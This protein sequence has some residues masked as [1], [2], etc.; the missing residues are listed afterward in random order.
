MYVRNAVLVMSLVILCTA[1]SGA[2]CLA[3][4]HAASAV[5]PALA[6]AA[7]S[8]PLQVADLPPVTVIST[9]QHDPVE[10]VKEGRARARVFLAVAEPS[11]A[12]KHMV[13]ELVEVVRLSTEAD[14][15]VV[16]RMPPKTAPALVIGDC[17]ESREA[18]IEADKIPVEGFVVKTA[19]N[20]V[21]LVGSTKTLPPNE[22]RNP[23]DPYGNE[24]TAWAVADFLERFVGVRWYWP[25]EVG[26]RCI[27][28]ATDLV[29][30]PVHYSDQPVFPMRTFYPPRYTLPLKSRWFDKDGITMG[31]PAIP[32]DLKT[33]EMT[34][35]LTCLRG[36]NSWPY[37]IKVH[38]PQQLWKNPELVKDH[39]E[40]FALKQNGERNFSMLCYGN[41]ATVDFLVAGGAAYWDKNPEATAPWNKTYVSWVTDTCM[42]ISP[43]DEPV[44][45]YCPQCSALWDPAAGTY[46]SGSKI[47][48]H[49]VKKVCEK[50][51]QRWPDKKVLYLA[52]W[53]YTACPEEIDFPDNLEVQMCTMATGLM[54]QPAARQEMEKY[55]RAWSKKVGGRITTWEYP[56]RVPEWTHAPVQYPNV[57]Q[58]YYRDNRELLAGSFLNGGGYNE[59]SKG[60]PTDYCW[61]RILWN[62]DVN[63]EAILDEMCKRLFG[64][65]ATTTRELLRLQVE[66]FEQAPWREGVGDA[67]HIPPV[68]Y[69]DT[70]PPEVVE[71]M[72]RLR[73]K[74]LQELQDDPVGQQRLYYLTWT[75]DAFL[76]EAK[77]AWEK[78]KG[79]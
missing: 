48:G 17:E 58:S 41:E 7:E 57:V 24:A 12:L 10:I 28:K 14:L 34:P 52:Y 47:M 56:H 31:P 38:N 79:G 33:I 54:R 50:V 69:T 59:W 15:L 67:G 62:P 61:M 25:T 60:A 74:A 46:G 8:A 2:G 6:G 49:F 16:D 71:E 23:G 76:E 64:K 35:F 72:S 21:F 51:K 70:W 32:A 4:P 3:G 22:G 78:A 1:V 68:A 18:G 45:C 55:L 44:R 39:P 65:A 63:V 11:A 19:P 75:W 29:I 40:L 30:P 37:L 5:A 36:G 43:G 53:N 20:R 66:R 27:T 9:P 13:Q 42:T 26:G 77:E 73:A